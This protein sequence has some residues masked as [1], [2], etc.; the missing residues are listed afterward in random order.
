MESNLLKPIRNQTHVNKFV[1]NNF[2]RYSQGTVSEAEIKWNEQFSDETLQWKNIYLAV[3]KSTNDIKLRN[4]QYKYIMRIVP[5][6]QLLTKCNIVGSALCEFCSMEIETVSHL[7]WECAH[8]QQF[9]TS[10]ADLLRVCDSN[11]NI[12]VKTITFGICHSKPKCD[13]VVINFIIFWQNI[14]FFK[15]NK[16][17]KCQTYMFSSTTCL[18]E[19]R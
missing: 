6:N 7:F 13:A 12:T 4:F 5:T 3:F 18:T 11:I 19:L 14:L 2:M 8:G 1:Y 9:R 10:V 17:K 15:T 16:I